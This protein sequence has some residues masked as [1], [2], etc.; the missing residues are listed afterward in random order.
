MA[1]CKRSICV[2]L[3]CLLLGFP[4]LG[5]QWRVFQEQGQAF[6][7]AGKADSALY[8]FRKAEV[9]FP[10]RHQ[11]SLDYAKLLQQIG[12]VLYM[13]QSLYE[14]ARPYYH[15]AAGAIA[16]SAGRNSEAF[17][18]NL[19]YLGQLDY[20]LRKTSLAIS[21]YQQAK[22]IYAALFTTM[23]AKYSGLCN[24]LGVLYND[25]GN[26]TLASM[27]HEEAMNIRQQMNG[28]RSAA[29]AQSA[30]NLAAVYWSMGQLDKAE[31]LALLAK[32]LRETLPAVPKPQLAISCVSLGNVYR[33][34]GKF[35]E[36][37]LLYKQAM[38]IR[39]NVFSKNHEL[40][41]QSC[42]ILSNLYAYQSKHAQAGQLL[43]EAKA[44]RDTLG[45]TNTVFYGQNCSNLAEHFLQAGAYDKAVALAIA[46]RK[47]YLGMGKHALP[48]LAI[49]N[50][51]LGSIY[52]QQRNFKAAEKY[53]QLARKAW[54]SELGKDHPNYTA[55]SLNM[56]RL[57]MFNAQWPLA[58][59]YYYEAFQAQQ[60]QAELVFAF[61]AETEK[62]KFLQNVLDN[63]DEYLSFAYTYPEGKG[64]IFGM[65]V[66][67]ARKSM[68]LAS[69]Q[70][71]QYAANNSNDSLV[72]QR[73]AYWLSLKR[74]MSALSFRQDQASM[75]FRK[76]VAVSADSLEKLLAGS[77]RFAGAQTNWKTAAAQLKATDAV[78]EFTSFRHFDG[79]R[80]TDSARYAALLL[81]PGVEEVSW[82]DL[83]EKKTLDSLVK[84]AYGVIAQLGRGNKKLAPARNADQQICT[85]VW[86]PIEP[87]LSSVK[88]V[89]LVPGGT[90][91]QLAFATLPYDSQSV[92][93]DH[94]RLAQLTSINNLQTTIVIEPADNIQLMGGIDYGHVDTGA[95]GKF[96][97]SLPGTGRE[98]NDIWQMAEVQSRKT[99]ILKDAN[100]TEAQF[101][102]GLSAESPAIIHL[103]THG[104]YLPFD[105]LASADIFTTKMSRLEDPMLRSGLAFAGANLA[106]STTDADGSSDDGILTAFEIANLDLSHTK[107]VVLSA[108]ETAL[109]DLE[110][111]EGVYGL[112]RAFKMAGAQYIIMSL[113]EVP[114]AETAFF[115]KAFYEKLLG[116]GNIES[117]FYEARQLL[118]EYVKGDKAK[119]GAW[120]LL[121]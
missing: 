44:I 61:T 18:D 31:P 13:Q 66:S 5:Q 64:A 30:N 16:S 53:L 79:F 19:F 36:A 17:A 1:N 87:Y 59:R 12:G 70:Q 72:H 78:I 113:W 121:N 71:L 50:N 96:F 22:R 100:A 62:K 88:N 15:R 77:A 109:G 48:D 74:Q 46:A 83:C 104:F 98:V 111:N 32:Q 35:S 4:S 119:W 57:A 51:L 67:Q 9:A 101:R 63:Q 114:D 90:L 95:T 106:F 45:N 110:G 52:Y 116:T 97:D 24:A 92:L 21:E 94:F 73:F 6:S 117:S 14:K 112:Q 38:Q 26:F 29:Y 41:A 105:S 107:L 69:M 84:T 60:K 54:A 108:C 65:D 2:C 81:K 23:H 115:M 102:K 118:K 28:T 7:K 49:V 3:T 91:N 75:R 33:D 34:M 120:V 42:D 20:L 39:E 99:T 82:I 68:I 85:M 25:A 89:Y 80:Q 8:Y 76:S 58:A 56:A 37:E 40:Y 93:S 103:A 11:R 47:I 55:S 43:M 10:T 86:K 27:Q